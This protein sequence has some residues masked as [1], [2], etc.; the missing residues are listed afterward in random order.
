MRIKSQMSAYFYNLS[1][2]NCSEWFANI[3]Y[4]SKY[5]IPKQ[6]GRINNYNTPTKTNNSPKNTPK[7]T[8][9]LLKLK[10]KVANRFRVALPC[11]MYL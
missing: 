6:G 4:S 3:I 5:I 9:T 2:T 11:T 10:S 1:L 8:Q 7:E